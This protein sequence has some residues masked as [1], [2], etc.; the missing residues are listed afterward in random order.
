MPLARA[1]THNETLSRPHSLHLFCLHTNNREG[2]SYRRGVRLMSPPHLVYL[3]SSMLTAIYAPL[4]SPSLPLS[5]HVSSLMVIAS[6]L[7][8]S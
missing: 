6:H 7:H 1:N 8:L 3:P 2:D 4:F 5:P